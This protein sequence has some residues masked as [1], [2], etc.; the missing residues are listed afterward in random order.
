[1]LAMLSH[2]IY[3]LEDFLGIG[4]VQFMFI[5]ENSV[6]TLRDAWSKLE[7]LLEAIEKF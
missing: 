2:E 5:K 1:M 6:Q 7:N 4:I 3:K